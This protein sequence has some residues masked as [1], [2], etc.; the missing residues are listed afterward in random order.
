LV[1]S[2]CIKAFSRDVTFQYPNAEKTAI[3]G[4]SFTIEP[5]SICVIV[6]DNGT[7]VKFAHFTAVL[8]KMMK[9]VAKAAL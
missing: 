4:L 1:V 7:F 2:P 8:T 6:G 3:D 5:G 9:A